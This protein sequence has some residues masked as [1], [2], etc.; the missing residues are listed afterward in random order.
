MTYFTKFNDL[1]HGSMLA[2]L[3]A[4]MAVGLVDVARSATADAAPAVKVGYG[5]L[6]LKSAQGAHT[7]HARITAAARQ[8][9]ALDSVDMRDLPAFTAA[10]SCETQAI[11]NA[12][13]EVQATTVA[14]LAAR[15]DQG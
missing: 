8:V 10:R 15:H 14:S 7:L 9:C 2:A 11:A 12:E 13:R 1:W 3:T 4:C 6:D 5:D